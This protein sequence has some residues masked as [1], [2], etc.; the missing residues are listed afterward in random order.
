LGSINAEHADVDISLNS[1]V[2]DQLRKKT[3]KNSIVEYLDYQI[4]VI[5]LKGPKGVTVGVANFFL[6]K[7]IGIDEDNTFQLKFLF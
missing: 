2:W 3:R 1:K 6:G 4:P 7:S 5:Q